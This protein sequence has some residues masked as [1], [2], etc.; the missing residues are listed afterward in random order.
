MKDRDI[1][2]RGCGEQELAKTIANLEF[3][4]AERHKYRK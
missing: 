3:S 4:A 2:T 1:T